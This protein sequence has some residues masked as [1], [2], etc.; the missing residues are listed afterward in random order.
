MMSPLS[1]ASQIMRSKKPLRQGNI[2]GHLQFLDQTEPPRG[3]VPYPGKGRA[4]VPS[5]PRPLLFLPGCTPGPGA[6]RVKPEDLASYRPF[7]RLPMMRHR[8]GKTG[9][10][11]LRPAVMNG[12]PGTTPRPTGTLRHPSRK[13]EE[14]APG[15]VHGRTDHLLL[16]PDMGRSRTARDNILGTVRNR[17]L[18]EKRIDNLSLPVLLYGEMIVIVLSQFF[19]SGIA[20]GSV[21]RLNMH[22]RVNTQLTESIP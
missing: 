6:S 11:V 4:G 12:A 2:S 21:P 14:R 13:R 16:P 10:S 22:V 5:S 9:L 1:G 8:K 3:N 7:F 17:P 18:K 19:E 15:P 20:L